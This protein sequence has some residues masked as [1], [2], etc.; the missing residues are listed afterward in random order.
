MKRVFSLMLE[1]SSLS[2]QEILFLGLV[3]LTHSTKTQGQ[4][5]KR[6]G[7]L[8]V[9][10]LTTLLKNYHIELNRGQEVNF[11]LK[12]SLSVD[13]SDRKNKHLIE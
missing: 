5:V 9:Q 13:L 8:S 12:A 4:P 2:P 10:V 6:S 1:F 11:P 3:H 7:Q